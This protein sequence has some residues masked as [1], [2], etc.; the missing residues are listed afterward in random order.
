MDKGYVILMSVA[1]IAIILAIGLVLTTPA[2]ISI[3][4]TS[5]NSSLYNGQDFAIKLTQYGIPIKN[6]PINVTFRD[7]NNGSNSMILTTN[8]EGVAKITLGG[9]TPGN[10]T[11]EC[12]YSLNCL[13][14]DTSTVIHLNVKK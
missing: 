5:E 3:D 13:H 6:Q 12:I 4:N 9:V 11:V 10:Y 8:S 2:N 14:Q 1:I 7:V